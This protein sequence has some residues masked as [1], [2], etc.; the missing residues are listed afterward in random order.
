MR[1]INDYLQSGAPAGSP[2]R[3]HATKMEAML[4]KL[5][6]QLGSARPDA[7]K[8]D[9]PDMTITWRWVESLVEEALD[10]I[11]SDME[12]EG[13]LSERTAWQNQ[14]ALIAAIATGLYLPPFRVHVLLT[15]THPRWSGVVRCADPDCAMGRSCKGN[16]LRLDTIAP[17]TTSSWEH[18]DYNTTQVTNVVVHHKN[19]R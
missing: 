15:M 18:F 17:K 2:V 16:H 5:Q 11:D 12:K 14:Q 10:Q 4:S 7:P 13:C 3:A 1:K 8:T 6:T 19:D 9:A